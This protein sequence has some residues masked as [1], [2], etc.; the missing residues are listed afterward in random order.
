M[1]KS[2]FDLRGKKA[3]VTG[4][5]RG[6]GKAMAEA[7]AE[8]GADIIAVSQSIET[9]GSDIEKAVSAKGR[10]CWAYPCDFSD[11]RSVKAFLAK[12]NEEHPDID[13]LINNAGTIKRAPAVEHSDAFWDETIEVNLNGLCCLIRL[14]DMAA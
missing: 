5:K 3:L 11:R 14:E 7:L 9:Q 4:A 13:I 1:E 6:I 8:A 10:Q 12:I 2:A